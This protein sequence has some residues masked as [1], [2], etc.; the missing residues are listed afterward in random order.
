MSEDEIEYYRQRAQIERSRAADAV[1]PQIAE[2]HLKL[3]GLYEEFIQDKA[4]HRQ[5]QSDVW[6]LPHTSQQARSNTQQ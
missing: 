1:T 4:D 5:L 6:P 3:A 2:I